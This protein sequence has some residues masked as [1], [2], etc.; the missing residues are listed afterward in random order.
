MGISISIYLWQFPSICLNLYFCKF[1]AITGISLAVPIS[2]NL[3]LFCLYLSLPISSSLR[4]LVFMLHIKVLVFMLHICVLVF[5][6]HIKV[7]VFMLHI[8]VLV[9]MLHICVLVFMLHIRVLVFMLHIC[10]LVFMLH[11][12]VLVFM[13][14]IRVLVFMLHICVLVFTLHI[15]VLVFLRCTSCNCLGLIRQINVRNSPR[16]RI[17]EKLSEI[18]VRHQEMDLQRRYLHLCVWTCIQMRTNC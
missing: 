10:V 18:C 15:C 8:C 5:M 17:S 3:H 1:L 9:F 4:V 16:T 6:L 11:I 13:L 7:L 12:C 2:P 14:H